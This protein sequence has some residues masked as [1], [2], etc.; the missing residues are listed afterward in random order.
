MKGGLEKVSENIRAAEQVIRK[1]S[2]I[3]DARQLLNYNYQCQGQ[4]NQKPER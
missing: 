4:A 2:D 1:A 3:P